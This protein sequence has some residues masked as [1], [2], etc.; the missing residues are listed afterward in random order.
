[1]TLKVFLLMLGNFFTKVVGLLREVLFAAWFGAGETAA[2][3]KIAQTGFLMPTHAFVGDALSAGL[4]PLYKKLQME[5]VDSA[6]IL[7]LVA[8]GY[9]LIFSAVVSSLLYCFSDVVV[10]FMA[11]GATDDAKDLAIDLLRIM[12]LATPFYVLSGIFSY[13]EASFGYYGAIALRPVMLNFGAIIGAALAVYFKQ[14]HWLATALLVSHVL[15]FAKTLLGIRALDRL[16][17]E[18]K[19]TYALVFE[20]SKKFFL[21]LLP[22][23]G[24]PLVAQGNVLVERIVSSWMGTSVI[25]SVDYARLILDTSVQLLAVPLGIVTMAA[26]GGDAGDKARF[27]ARNTAAVLVVLS[28]PFGL[29]VALNAEAVVTLL[30]ARGQFGTEAIA[31]TTAM[32]VWMGVGLGFMVTAYYLIKVLNAQMRNKEA[33][34]I[35]VA[36]VLV[37]MAVNLFGWQYMGPQTIGLGLAAYGAMLF[38]LCVWRLNYWADMKALFM[39]TAFGCCI[40]FGLTEIVFVFLSYPYAIMGAATAAIVVWLPMLLLCSPMKAAVKPLLSRVP[41]L[42]RWV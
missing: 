30:Y 5:C 25:P 7:V 37:N 18:G 27:F 19:Q 16:L 20:V 42:R 4:L 21:N 13:L 15:F 1:M 9:A 26:H 3:F 2:A 29:F 39:W 17:P 31:T 12:G 22:L 32:L 28:F 14:D 36:A 24:L 11:P 38:G 33:L 6:R 23:L 35:T 41:I 40:Q 8:V 10:N 34:L